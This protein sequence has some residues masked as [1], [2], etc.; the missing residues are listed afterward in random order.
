[1]TVNYDAAQALKE[2]TSLVGD[3]AL[4]RLCET[5][6]HFAET[7]LEREAMDRACHAMAMELHNRGFAPERALAALK[8]ARCEPALAAQH[9]L[10]E[11]AAALRYSHAVH[12]LTTYYFA[13][14]AASGEPGS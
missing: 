5:L 2:A 13:D 10:T 11:T 1:V 3:T 12:C 8:I 7:G 9:D 6:T 4:N 14:S